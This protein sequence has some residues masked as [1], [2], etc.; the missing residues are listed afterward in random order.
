M[1]KS[2]DR[3]PAEVR[4]FEILFAATKLFCENDYHLVSMEDVAAKVGVSKATV[5]LYFSSKLELFFG[6]IDQAVDRLHSGLEDV[7][8]DP[9]NV[10]LEDKLDAAQ[11]TL[12]G[13][14]PIFSATQQLMATGMPDS[15]FPPEM[16]AQFMKKMHGRRQHLMQMF[17]DLFTKAQE[18][19]EVRVDLAPR[20]L[21]TVFGV[22]GMLMTRSEVPYETAKEILF[23]GILSSGEKK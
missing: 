15:D 19:K 22:Y 17:I 9:S 7:F 13:Y 16:V 6:V 12:Q 14:A 1:E 23:H 2:Q 3:K 18:R 10:S 21:A 11:R 5:Y 4:K 8:N 20:E